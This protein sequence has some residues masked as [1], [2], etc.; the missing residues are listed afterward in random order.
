VTAMNRAWPSVVATL[1]PLAFPF[2]V[3]RRR[4]LLRELA[5]APPPAARADGSP[6]DPAAG[7]PPADWY[8]DPARDVRVRY[9]DG[10]AWTRHGAR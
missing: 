8:P 10:S 2:Y 3:R 1:G 6:L 7:A 9:W 5:S 4:R